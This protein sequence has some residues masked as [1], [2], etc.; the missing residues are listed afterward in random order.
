MA[1][2]GRT[3]IPDLSIGGAIKYYQ[4]TLPKNSGKGLT[5]DI[6]LLYELTESKVMIG[7]VGRNLLAASHTPV[8]RKTPSIAHLDS[9][10][11]LSQ[12]TIF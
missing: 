3:V 9:A 6:G 12:W 2:Y 10:F 11:R 5:A 1:G 4:Q 8:A 7:A